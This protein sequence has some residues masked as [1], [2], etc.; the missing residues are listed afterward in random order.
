MRSVIV[1]TGAVDVEG[2]LTL[3]EG[4]TAI[5]LFVHGSGSSR[6]SPRNQAVAEEFN[7]FGLGTLLFDLLTESEEKEDLKTKDLRFN[8]PLLAERV[9]GAVKW[10]DRNPETRLLKMGLIGSST[11]AAA[12]LVAA[13]KMG[14]EIHAVVSR[15]GRPDLAGES[16]KHVSA[17]TLLIVGERDPQVLELNQVAFREL[18]SDKSLEVIPGASHLFEETGTLEQAS[19]L[20]RGWFLEHLR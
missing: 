4:A 18:E 2:F 8:I 9:V 6:H 11:G 15:G 12:A 20:A 13:A 17:P 7:E 5:V 16:L 14:T 10:L 1:Q 19:H 3:P